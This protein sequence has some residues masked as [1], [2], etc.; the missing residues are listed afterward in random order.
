MFGINVKVKCKKCGYEDIYS[1]G[2]T[3]IFRVNGLITYVPVKC[4][5]C[6]ALHYA[7]EETFGKSEREVVILADEA[8]KIEKIG[9]C[10]Y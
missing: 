5:K 8:E 4:D 7:A 2:I 3:E 10:C 1:I 9:T 6:G